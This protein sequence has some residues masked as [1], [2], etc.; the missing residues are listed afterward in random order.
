MS[1]CVLGQDDGAGAW[2]A[3]SDLE[4]H[5]HVQLRVKGLH[6]RDKQV[7]CGGTLIGEEWVLTAAECDHPKLEALL[8]Q[9]RDLSKLEKFDIKERHIH[10]DTSKQQLILLH[11]DRSW[12]SK[13]F[14]KDKDF[15][16]PKDKCEKPAGGSTV[17]M[18][19]WKETG[20]AVEPQEPLT[21]N[22]TLACKQ[23]PVAECPDFSE[24][25]DK[26]GELDKSFSSTEMVCA[27]TE[28][29]NTCSGS[30]KASCSGP[31]KLTS[32]CPYTDWILRITKMKK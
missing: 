3:C 27:G 15:S 18:V 22:P 23:L 26:E 30:T 5:H 6:K 7:R 12:L 13:V 32:I 1:R 24:Y 20:L 11:L 14:K 8:R 31:I 16:F 25:K 17:Q 28:T 19:G 21:T 9:G 4:A 10:T 2:P 29:D